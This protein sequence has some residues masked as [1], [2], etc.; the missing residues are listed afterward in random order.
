LTLTFSLSELLEPDEILYTKVFDQQKI[1]ADRQASVGGV[2]NFQTVNSSVLWSFV[3]V[4]RELAGTGL[5][6]SDRRFRGKLPVLR[7]G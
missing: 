7:F 2:R 4:R 5:R 1:G 6:A 3:G